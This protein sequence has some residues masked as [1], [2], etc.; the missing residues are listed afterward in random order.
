VITLESEA[1]GSGRQ[2]YRIYDAVT[3]LVEEGYVSVADMIVRQPWLDDSEFPVEVT[4]RAAPG[5][6]ATPV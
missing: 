2:Q 1:A 3:G 5:A 4:R 6:Q